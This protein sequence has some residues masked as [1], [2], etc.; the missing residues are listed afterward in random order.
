MMQFSSLDEDKYET[1]AKRMTYLKIFKFILE[2]FVS[3]EDAKIMMKPTNLP[4]TTTVKTIV[5]TAV[6]VPTGAGTGTGAGNGSGSGTAQP[7]YVG[8][9][10]TPGS[11]T[12]EQQHKTELESGG[13]SVEGFTSGIEETM[14]TG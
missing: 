14:A 2:D 10:K 5:N 3:R 12:L 11:V 8:D 7:S 6:T 1:L 13:A 9:T 4:V